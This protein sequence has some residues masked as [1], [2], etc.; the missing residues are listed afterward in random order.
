[1]KYQTDELFAVFFSTV[2]ESSS[3]QDFTQKTASFL[4]R[5]MPVS[6]VSFCSFDRGRVSRIAEYADAAGPSFPRQTVIPED[7]LKRLHDEE[8]FFSDDLH[9]VK[10]FTGEETCVFAEWLNGLF[11][12]VES[13]GI[14]IPIRHQVLEG[15]HI[16]LSVCSIG[17]NRYRQDHL[18]ICMFMQ[19]MLRDTFNG[20]LLYNDMA[21]LRSRFAEKDPAAAQGK[22]PARSTQA[23]DAFP[24]LDDVIVT[25]IRSAIAQ[26]GGKIA[27]PD[28]AAG[29]LGLNTSTLWSKI[30]KYNIDPKTI[31]G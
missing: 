10:M 6:A 26:A 17:K 18:D 25:H 13:S 29:L 28:G 31:T 24:S 22:E 2:F 27:G 21:A 1:M 19:P 8:H 11:N 30:R 7:I 9:A 14:Y 3:L 4:K 15:M 20:I 5:Y 23:D 16:Y 12:H